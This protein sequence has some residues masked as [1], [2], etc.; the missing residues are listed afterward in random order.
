[1]DADATRA[2][3]AVCS[4]TAVMIRAGPGLRMILPAIVSPR[5]TEIVTSASATKPEARL[6]SHQTCRRVG[7]VHA[8]TALCRTEAGTEIRTAG[9]ALTGGG[10][11]ADRLDLAVL[12][13]DQ[14]AAVR[15]AT[16][17]APSGPSSSAAFER[18][19]AS[20]AVSASAVA[21]TS[22]VQAGA[23][24]DGSSR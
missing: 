4:W 5:P 15:R 20:S 12:V 18:V 13:D 9:V 11:A 1:M 24:V 23:P 2:A 14:S 17:R 6:A 19:S 8:A 7:R 3:R 21:P 16:R 22:P 10:A